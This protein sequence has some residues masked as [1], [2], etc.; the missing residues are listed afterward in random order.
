MKVHL[1]YKNR[2][3][4]MQEQEP[5]GKEDLIKDLGLDVIF[6]SM[7][8]EDKFIH[9][10]VRH[11]MLLSLTEIETINYRQNILNDCINNPD[12]VR[13]LYSIALETID[14]EKSNHW[15][16]FSNYPES[17]LRRSI[18][19]MKMYVEMLRKLRDFADRSKLH[20]CSDGFITL[21]QMLQSELDDEYLGSIQKHIQNLSSGEGIQFSAVLG[22]GFK[23]IDF[24][25]C[26]P[27]EK[28]NMWK[29]FAR[30]RKVPSFTYCLS[31]MDESG[32]KALSELRDRGL[33]TVANAV[34]QSC[35][36]ILSFFQAVRTE[37]AFY[38]GC[39]NLID[40]LKELNEPYCIPTPLSKECRSHTIKGLFNIAFAIRTNNQIIGNDLNADGK[41]LI[42]ITGANQGGKT[43][44]LMSVG[45]AQTM[46]QCGMFVGAE[47]FTANICGRIFTHFKR[48]ED[49]T[50]K[51]GKLDEELSRMNRIADVMTADSLILFNES[52]ASTNERE[53][54]EIGAQIT[55]ALL[56][57]GIKIFTVT[58]LYQFSSDFYN[59]GREDT[60]FLRAERNEDGTRNYK[61]TIGE[62]LK[63]GFGEDL[64]F[65]LF[66][67]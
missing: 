37:L 26:E 27:R 66:K 39:L 33:N 38:I 61:L 2:D 32:A 15:G 4:D 58:H 49:E 5:F 7:A 20:F 25:L 52:F 42:I 44:F 59:Q 47:Q 6:E 50:M 36:H 24:N 23:G 19:V 9:S 48:E 21:F 31:A 40:H 28:Q 22:E 13:S 14:N 55:R 63:T 12:I 18:E 54:S 45:Q 8:N 41:K 34:A 3:F 57:K 11:A 62:P 43:I 17:I 65:E 67:Q 1:M 30:S 60:L 10:V 53:G 64:Y 16:I 29:E 56:E 46:M 35:E 51:S